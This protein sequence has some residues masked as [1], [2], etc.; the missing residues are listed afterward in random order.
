MVVVVRKK[1]NTNPS[2]QNKGH[3]SKDTRS[4]LHLNQD[5]L[6]LPSFL[7]ISRPFLPLSS[8]LWYTN[9][10]LCQW[11]CLTFPP[12]LTAMANVHVKDWLN[13]IGAT[14]K[15]QAHKMCKRSL[16]ASPVG[17]NKHYNKLY[18]I[19]NKSFIFCKI[20]MF[21]EWY[22]SAL[23]FKSLSLLLCYTFIQASQEL[24]KKLKKIFFKNFALTTIHKSNLWWFMIHVYM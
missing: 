14:S 15:R 20:F 4:D 11:H 12:T 9:R 24:A 23:S 22:V 19:Y 21:F 2:E 3:N 13:R 17:F 6:S 7:V 18:F 16:V 5:P 1:E 8:F 10:A